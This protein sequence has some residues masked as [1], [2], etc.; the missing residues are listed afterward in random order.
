MFAWRS[1][2]VVF[3]RAL[4]EMAVLLY[5]WVLSRVRRLDARTPGT[6]REAIA[7]LAFTAE[8]RTFGPGAS[9]RSCPSWV[10][11]LPQLGHRLVHRPSF[12]KISSERR[13]DSVTSARGR[14]AFSSQAS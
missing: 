7:N 6:Y 8:F 9:S 13:S 4:A 11:K 12:S 10:A 5:A 1:T 2:T 3:R 14:R